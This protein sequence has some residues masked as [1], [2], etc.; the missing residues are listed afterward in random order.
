M[1]NITLKCPKCGQTARRPL[2]NEPGSRGVHETCSEPAYCPRGHGEMA[3][4]DGRRNH[5]IHPE[6]GKPYWPPRTP[7]QVADI[8]PPRRRRQA[9]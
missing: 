3:R 8:K 5:Y 2:V 6:T 7:Y 4:V 1:P 9:L